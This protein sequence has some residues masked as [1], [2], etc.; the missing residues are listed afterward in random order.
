MSDEFLPT[1]IKD[2]L[3]ES[4]PYK[5]MWMDK[6]GRV[7]YGNKMFLDR[8]EYHPSEITHLTVFDINPYTNKES[9]KEHWRVVKLRG[10][11][12]F[13][14][15]HQTKKGKY[16]D[17][18]I[19]AQFF[20][21]AD[22]EIVCAIVNEITE[23]SFYKNLLNHA[24]RM[25]QVGGWKLDLQDDSVV[26]TQQTLCI[27]SKTDKN[28]L[29]PKNVVN[30]FSEKEE[31]ERLIDAA[32]KKGASFDEIFTLNLENHEVKYIR[33]V[34][35]PIL[36]GHKIYKLIG[37]YQDV[38]EETLKARE[39]STFKYIVDNTKD[40][41]HFLDKDLQFKYVNQASLEF[42]GQPEQKVIQKNLLDFWPN[43]LKD[44]PGFKLET[45]RKDEKR[46]FLWENQT[47]N[48]KLY[49]DATYL[50]IDYLGEELVCG[51]TRNI[52]EIKQKEQ[53]L[54][55]ALIQLESFKLIIDNAPEIIFFVDNDL[56]FRYANKSTATFGKLR[57]PDDLIG[58]SILDFG[59][60]KED[61]MEM[62]IG[63]LREKDVVRFPYNFTYD[64]K[65]QY[66]EITAFRISYKEEDLI[67]VM[68]KDVTALKEKELSL[69]KALEELS[70]LKE[71]LVI[72]NQNLREEINSNINFG[73]IICHSEAY[74][75]VLD[76]VKLVASTDSTVLISGESGTGKELLAT[77]VHINS[78]RKENVFIKVNCAT[79]PIELIESELFGHKKG[80]FTGAYADKPGKFS[81][82]D[83]GTI[84]LDE[85]GE[86][87]LDLQA[88]LLRVLQE[89]EFDQLG[90]TR[91]SK[92]DVRV[93]AATNRNLEDMVSEGK[94][95]EDLYYRLNVFPIRNIPLRERKEDISFL[96]Q[97]FLQ[98][99][100][101]KAGKSFKRLSK[102][103]I[104]KLMLYDFPGNIRE[105]ENLIERAVIV[106]DGTTLFPGSWMPENKQV[107][108][109]TNSFK[110]FEEM[111]R[112]Y[113]YE[114]L[115]STN[116][117]VSGVGGAA[118]VLNMKDKTLFARMKKLGIEKK[119]ILKKDF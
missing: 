110:S 42:L 29:H 118:E 47:S 35:E 54:K 93:V 27:F 66:I 9:W 46:D 91:T 12:N 104:E 2:W 26:V 33:C 55:N 30:Y 50:K 37:A 48:G 31:L 39:L 23:S 88:K 73:N 15:V 79:L 16:Y 109:R 43:L 14:A 92:V 95:R 4:L 60:R 113:I 25:T 1:N 71:E 106:E 82:A 101:V 114:V 100:T 53:G 115:V 70:E 98:K 105:L 58:K 62:L 94:F 86:V 96:A 64:A 59:I 36:N 3:I 34:V 13:K 57:V 20:S 107:K 85:I 76:Q 102:K 84:F 77:A 72:D 56:K 11:H 99:Y 24:E 38:T 97:F 17:V 69:E 78:K 49:F 74:A 89:G 81:L 61:M 19:H 8:L 83:G 119:L 5:I 52:T 111:Q 51:I 67:G 68:L 28:D 80:S 18:E 7:I 32:I 44:E 21:Y 103:A 117:K 6:E 87:P 75:K 65:R 108:S 90:S 112:D 40:Y 22:K 116:G 63:G 10:T 45:I 41:I